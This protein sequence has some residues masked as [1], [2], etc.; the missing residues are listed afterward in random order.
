MAVTHKNS[1]GS[2]KPMP[3]KKARKKPAR[4]ILKFDKELENISG[5]ILFPA[6]LELANKFLSK[7][8]S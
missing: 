7:I 1:A 5:S 3:V 6:K 2:I 4:I 8:G